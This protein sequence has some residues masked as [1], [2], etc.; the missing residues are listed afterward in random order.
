MLNQS[1]QMPLLSGFHEREQ[2]IVGQGHLQTQPNPTDSE[3]T[4]Q[5]TIK[6]GSI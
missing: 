1:R 5:P 4:I 2:I 3:G 6:A